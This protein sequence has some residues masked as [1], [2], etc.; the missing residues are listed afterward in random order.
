MKE[1]SAVALII[2]YLYFP[3]EIAFVNTESAGRAFKKDSPINN[4]ESVKKKFSV[5]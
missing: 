2:Y 3:E 5:P 4:R 1:N